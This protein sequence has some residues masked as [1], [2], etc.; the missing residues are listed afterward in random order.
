MSGAKQRRAVICLETGQHFPSLFSAAKAYN[1]SHGNIVRACD[2]GLRCKSHRWEP[3]GYGR[4]DFATNLTTTQA[5]RTQTSDIDAT[6]I[7]TIRVICLSSVPDSD[8]VEILYFTGIDMQTSTE[9]SLLACTPVSI[10]LPPWPQA[11]PS[12]TVLAIQESVVVGGPP[13]SAGR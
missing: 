3:T 4:P 1:T 8:L 5:A 6:E 12:K 7:P 2:K 10:S 13:H 9:D 11:E